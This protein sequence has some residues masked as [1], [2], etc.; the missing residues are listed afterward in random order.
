M[1][2]LPS[3]SWALDAHGT[4]APPTVG[5]D[6]SS[7]V[8]VWEAG[9]PPTGVALTAQGARQLAMLWPDDGG[10]A[11]PILD[12]LVGFEV[13][14]A[15]RYKRF[16][17]AASIPLWAHYIGRDGPVT[18]ITPGDLRLHVPLTLWENAG[19]AVGLRAEGV[20]P[21]GLNTALLGGGWGGGLHATVGRRGT[22]LT[23]TLGAGVAGDSNAHF[24]N[25]DRT[26]TVPV[27]GQ[28]GY[29]NDWL[30][31]G[32][33]AWFSPS[34]TAT[35]APL[36]SAPAEVL[37]RVGI[38]TKFGLSVA[39]AGGYAAAPGIGSAGGR[40]VLRVGWSQPR[41]STV[42]VPVRVSDIAPG[43]NDVIVNVRDTRGKPVD[44]TV[45][46]RAPDGT[47]PEDIRTGRDGEA[48][49]P[50]SEGAWTIA[51]TAPGRAAQE[52][53]VVVTDDAWRPATIDAVLDKGESGAADLRVVVVDA[54]GA[55]VDQAMVRLD[56]A[57]RG[58]TSTGGTL[59]LVDLGAGERS[60][61]V[62]AEGYT[63][64]APLPLTVGVDDLE[65]TVVLT[66]APGSVRVVARVGDAPAT[67]AQVRFLG[68]GAPTPAEPLGDDGEA[69]LTLQ[70]GPWTAV[71]S[72]PSLGVQERELA[73]LPGQMALVHIEVRLSPS[74]GDASLGVRVID[75][76]GQPVGDADVSLDGASVG[77]TSSAGTLRVG[78]LAAGDHTLG[79]AGEMLRPAP[80][81]T[82]TLAG[83]RDVDLVLGWAPGT[84]SV[85]ARGPDGEPVDAAVRFA[86]RVDQP[87]AA[88]G[89]D[90]EELYNLPAG[91]WRVAVSAPSFGLQERAVRVEPDAVARVDID[92]SLLRDAGSAVL[93]LQVKG[94]DGAL[95]SNASVRIDDRDAGTLG[96]TGVLRL[97]GLAPGKHLIVVDGA[98]AALGSWSKELVLAAGDNPT[99]VRL[100]WA[101]RAVRVRARTP[102][103]PVTDA[104]ARAFGP[105]ARPLV[106][107][108]P[109]GEAVL[110]VDARPGWGVVASSQAF[111][112]VS[113]P[114]TASKVNPAE[115]DLRFAPPA[116][117]TSRL[118]VELRAP[119]GSLVRGAHVTAGSIDTTVDGSLVLSDLA[120]GKLALRVEAP[121][122]APATDALVLVEGAQE[123]RLRMTWLPRTLAI[124]VVDAKGA[125]VDAEVRLAGPRDLRPGSTGKDG[126]LDAEVTPGPWQV[127]A[128]APAFGARSVTVDVPPGQGPLPI[129]VTLN[130]ALVEVTAQAVRLDQPIH[131]GFDAAS[132]EPDST[133][134]LEQIVAALQLNP[135]ITGVEIQGHTDDKGEAIYNLDLSQRRAEAVR[136]WLVEAGVA[137]ARL[138]ARGYGAEVPVAPNTTEAGRKANRRVQL[139]IVARAGT[140]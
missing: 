75:P 84:L 35:E 41:P 18:G 63:P 42:A 15:W 91:D 98:D 137:P 107:L 10:A 23:W 100:G 129:T 45:S 95:V 6:P 16:G 113:A 54:T 39:L 27:A 138:T 66:A 112:V 36:A 47:G 19:L 105:D 68:T 97:A 49:V 77:R 3:L 37:A 61:V 139:V 131:F 67:G 70:P 134:V 130:A 135:D 114:L 26:L 89:L 140:P 50:L 20:A 59:T 82:V 96:G 43:P 44:A 111:G 21:T 108:G 94:P 25:V 101:D 93:A 117:G 99:E 120:P 80:P 11:I 51:V 24:G 78:G 9:A 122:Y 115:L 128:S 83:P 116:V 72:A 69:I 121:G 56:G 33:E 104:I 30:G 40:A 86:G 34:L 73:I 52:R 85:R 38:R 13:G 133:P 28:I 57:S 29:G 103:G 76:G 88:L 119:D 8:L 48:V 55:P 53:D 12:A 102:A 22:G 87:P 60:L 79:A 81:R 1:I 32:L 4:A 136:T 118:L 123:R 106:P 74:V 46:V 14:G 110:A 90:G 132:I 2:L 17:V 127:L 71:V 64:S 31:G 62:E 125:P 65:R 58:E 92:A 5:E 124:S 109:N 126:A 7:P